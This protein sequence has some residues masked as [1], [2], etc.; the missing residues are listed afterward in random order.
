M[1]A[2]MGGPREE[3]ARMPDV[4]TESPVALMVRRQKEEREAVEKRL[5]ESGH[6]VARRLWG[7]A[8]VAEG[9]GAPGTVA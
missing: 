5:T 3:E 2:M 6:T 4:D 9:E 7:R 1:P 8:V